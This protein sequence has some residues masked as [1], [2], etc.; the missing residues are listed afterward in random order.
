MNIQDLVEPTRYCIT[1]TAIVCA[2]SF[3]RAFSDV[4]NI[5]I[6]KDGIQNFLKPLKIWM[7]TMGGIALV[8]T[9]TTILGLAGRYLP[10]GV[11]SGFVCAFASLWWTP[12]QKAFDYLDDYK[13]RSL[14][15]YRSIFGAFLIAGA[16]L[17][18]FPPIFAM[19]AGI[20]D[21]L[22][23]WLAQSSK[24]SL[25]AEENRVW[26]YLT[27]GWGVL[28]LLDVAVLGTFIVRPWLIEK[29]SL[30]PSML[31]PW[32][33]VPLLLALNLHGLRRLLKKNIAP[34]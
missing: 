24:K 7:F 1:V 10:F 31:L 3:Y 27:H 11:A 32:M 33:A 30:G 4:E 9:H 17:E 29:Q 25:T 34:K 19:T 28:D 18:L 13:I 8:F 23:G 6:D 2:Y 20:G 5:R 22:A 21:L 26:R 15:S 16:A 12:A 14:M